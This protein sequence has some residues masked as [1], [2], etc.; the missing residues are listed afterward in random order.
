M[1]KRIG[2][3]VAA[4]ELLLFA[5]Q[6]QRR[7]FDAIDAIALRT[8]R[9]DGVRRYLSDLGVADATPAK[10]VDSPYYSVKFSGRQLLFVLWKP[11]PARNPGPALISRVR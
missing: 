9:A 2:S 1:L 11:K 6:E 7:V 5:C 4:D 3:R 10:P 8:L